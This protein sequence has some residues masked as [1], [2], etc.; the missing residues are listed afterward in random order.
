MALATNPVANEGHA[1]TQFDESRFARF[2]D[3]YRAA[4]REQVS[5]DP[6]YPERMRDD[7]AYCDLVADRMIAAIHRGRTCGTVCYLQSQAFRATSRALGVP[8][9]IKACNAWLR[10]Q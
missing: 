10:G 6:D 2:R 3:A 1:R 7:P 9:T 8:F 5:R 4:L